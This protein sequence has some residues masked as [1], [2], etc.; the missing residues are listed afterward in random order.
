MSCLK[1]RGIG[2]P[3]LSSRTKKWARAFH[4]SNFSGLS[5]VGPKLHIFSLQVGIQAGSAG[6]GRA[7]EQ[8]TLSAAFERPAR[9]NY[10]SREPYPKKDALSQGGA[11]RWISWY[12]IP[13]D[14]FTKI[15]G[16]QPGQPCPWCGGDHP[17]KS[18][19][20]LYKHIFGDLQLHPKRPK[21]TKVPAAY[22]LCG[23]ADL[24]DIEEDEEADQELCCQLSTP[25]DGRQTSHQNP[26]A[27]GAV[28]RAYN[29]RLE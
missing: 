25:K 2:T 27:K 14:T 24:S 1:I 15:Q 21:P 10:P 28:N 12:E 19:A 9:G 5:L 11:P 26:P 16:Q 7:P 29:P 23:T 4:N 18:C 3:R 17:Y 13:V 22:L 20:D 8:Q 6:F